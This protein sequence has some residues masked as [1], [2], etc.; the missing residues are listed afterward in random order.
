MLFWVC[1]ANVR[2]EPGTMGRGLRAIRTLQ[3]LFWH[4]Q[5]VA[6]QDAFVGRP[7][8]LICVNIGSNPLGASAIRGDRSKTAARCFWAAL[9]QDLHFR[10]AEI[11]I[12]SRW[13]VE[14]GGTTLRLAV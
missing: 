8:G 5:D 2:C 1:S 4:L 3:I 10:L 11:E 12:M 7:R 6:Y 14:Q 13:H 9:F